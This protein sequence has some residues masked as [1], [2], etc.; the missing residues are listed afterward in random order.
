MGK[1][2]GGRPLPP[3]CYLPL[4]VEKALAPPSSAPY[5]L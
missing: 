1:E 3:D 2:N 4:T 5:D